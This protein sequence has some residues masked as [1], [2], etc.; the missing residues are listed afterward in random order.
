MATVTRKGDLNG[1][2]AKLE[3]GTNRGLL[4]SALLVAQR[5]QDKAPVLSGRLKRSIT[6][7]EPYDTPDGKAINVGTNVAYAAAQELGAE[8]PPH[9]ITAVNAKALAF[10]WRGEQ[11]YYKRV[12]HPGAIIPAQ[13]YLRPALHDSKRDVAQI[14]A[15]SIVEAMRAP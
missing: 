13:P 1:A 11:R 8:I 4:L 6:T 3:N 9:E 7:S 14:L 5:G 12:N 15:V 2:A 10:E